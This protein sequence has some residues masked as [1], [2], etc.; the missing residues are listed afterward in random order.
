[1]SL[2]VRK[3]K[4]QPASV[5]LSCRVSP[6]IKSRAEEAARALGQTVTD[7]TKD[8][9]AKRA[10]EVL[11]EHNRILLSERDFAAFVAILNSPPKSAAPGLL[12]AAAE[13]E[14]QHP[15]QFEPAP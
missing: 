2:A 8:A 4:D 9:V 13:Y 5:R 6:V 15:S 12:A 11:A 7:F 3:A 10:E 14:R 1:M